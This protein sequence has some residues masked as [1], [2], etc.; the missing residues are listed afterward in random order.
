MIKR[1]EIIIVFFL[2]DNQLAEQNFFQQNTDNNIEDSDLSKRSGNF[3]LEPL[4][5]MIIYSEAIQLIEH[6]YNYS[7][8]Q[9]HEYTIQ[10]TYKVHKYKTENDYIFFT[11]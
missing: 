7:M 10:Y 1:L 3:S 9:L 11:Q 2:A 6:V 4:Y 5:V 8:R